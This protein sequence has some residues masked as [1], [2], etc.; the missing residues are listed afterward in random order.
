MAKYAFEAHQPV[1][2]CRH[3]PILRCRWCG[4][5][6]IKNDVTVYAIRLGCN[7]ADSPEWKKNFR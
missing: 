5:V 1:I 4:L 7:Y 2:L 3:Y 6:Y